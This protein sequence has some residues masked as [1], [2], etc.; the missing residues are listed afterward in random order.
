VL[1]LLLGLLVGVALA[2][3]RDALDTRPRNAREA[4]ELVGAPLLGQGRDALRLPAGT[5]SRRAASYESVAATVLLVQRKRPFRTIGVAAARRQG[6]AAMAAAGLASALTRLGP[7]VGLVDLHGGAAAH[8]GIEGGPG[9]ADLAAGRASAGDLPQ[10][11]WH[12]RGRRDP[13]IDSP[14]SLWVVRCGTDGGNAGAAHGALEALVEELSQRLDLVVVVAAPLGEPGGSA[15]QLMA[16]DVLLPVVSL[17]TDDREALDELR[18]TLRLVEVPVL[19]AIVTGRQSGHGS[20]AAQEHEL[21][22]GV[23]STREPSLRP[24][25]GMSG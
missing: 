15:L 3:L 8:F 10:Y 22:A 17:R 7:N 20:A 4:A 23:T 24:R 6:G 9:L 5:A 13:G 25:S 1:G 16:A 21:A 12:G 11:A 18:E 2:L 19:G 14:G